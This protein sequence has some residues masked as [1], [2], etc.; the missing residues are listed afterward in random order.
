LTV[1]DENR[2]QCKVNELITKNEDNNY[3]IEIK[4]RKENELELIRQRDSEN[5]YA[6]ILL[7]DKLSSVIDEIA[8]LKT[9]Y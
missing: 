9:R 6:I 1:E 2:L 4:L 8:K 5:T 7:S 3:L